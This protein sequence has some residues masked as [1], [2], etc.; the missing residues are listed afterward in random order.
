M[1]SADDGP[2]ILA[3]YNPHVILQT[4]SKNPAISC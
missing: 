3:L 1:R 4:E 2:T